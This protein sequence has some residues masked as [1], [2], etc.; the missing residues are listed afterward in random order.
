M[1]EL[2]DPGDIAD[3]ATTEGNQKIY[4]EDVRDVVAQSP[5]GADE[6]SVTLSGDVATIP[7]GSAFK[8]AGEGAT[9]DDLVTVSQ[10]NHPAGSVISIRPAVSGDTI[11]VKSTGNINLRNGGPGATTV[12][13]YSDDRMFLIRVG[14]AWW[15]IW[16]TFLMHADQRVYMGLGDAALEDVGSG[17]G[18]DAD[19]LDGEH[20]TAFLGATDVAFDSA[21]LGGILSLWYARKDLA[22]IQNFAGEVSAEA[23]ITAND[24]TGSTPRA[25][26]KDA[27]TLRGR[28]FFDPGNNATVMRLYDSDG[29]TIKG[30]VR[31]KEG[32]P[33]T[34]EYSADGSTYYT[35]WHQN[36]DG[37]GSG[38]DA[39]FC[40]G[41]DPSTFMVGSYVRQS[42]T[43][44]F[45][46]TD[47]GEWTT[48]DYDNVFSWYMSG[49]PAGVRLWTQFGYDRNL[50]KHGFM[51]QSDSGVGT[52]T[53]NV[54]RLILP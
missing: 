33:A 52:C 47:D 13:S 40:R 5:G 31:V 22:A 36:N 25:D 12:L 41:V 45:K 42:F 20:A 38:L 35:V 16:T 15:E 7:V 3:N 17:N 19:L 11:T 2:P 44:N 1:S 54:T 50:N 9:D 18:L 39:D 6:E 14:A 46:R 37:A 8:L 27:G 53:M 48:Y 34:I 43:L 28:V 51:T 10:T 23:A 32:P 26:L 21:R 30:N 4:L 49:V 24:S 29:S